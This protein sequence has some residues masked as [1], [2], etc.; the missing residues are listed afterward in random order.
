MTLKFRLLTRPDDG[1][2]WVVM[3]V[4]DTSDPDLVVLQLANEGGSAQYTV[5]R[6]F[7]ES[8]PVARFHLE[9]VRDVD[10]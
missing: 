4:G 8:L 2:K 3:A 5:K 9:S 10:S 7:Y 1:S 6:S